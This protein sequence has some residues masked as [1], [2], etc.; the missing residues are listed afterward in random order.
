MKK[1]LLLICFYTKVAQSKTQ[2][3]RVATSASAISAQIPGYSQVF[4][5]STKTYNYSP[6]IPQVAQPAAIAAYK[7]VISRVGCIH[8]SVD[9]DSYWDAVMAMEGGTVIQFKYL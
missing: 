7:D 1:L 3:L 8:S 4:T 6:S 2:I 5:I 9:H